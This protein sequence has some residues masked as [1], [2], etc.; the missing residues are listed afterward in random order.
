MRVDCEWLIFVC[1]N[2]N[3]DMTDGFWTRKYWHCLFFCL[4][5]SPLALLLSK[6]CKQSGYLSQDLHK[7]ST[8]LTGLNC[9][10]ITNICFLFHVQYVLFL[11]WLHIVGSHIVL[12]WLKPPLAKMIITHTFPARVWETWD[13]FVLALSNYSDCQQPRKHLT[14]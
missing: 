9:T 7:I 10:R 13:M 5:W 2:P 4:T 14:L 12:E 8:N 1:K 11:C 6:L 3:V